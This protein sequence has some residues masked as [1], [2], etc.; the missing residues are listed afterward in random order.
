MSSV[1]C[2]RCSAAV[3]S[4]PDVGTGV[5]RCGGCGCW[6]CTGEARARLTG[7]L[8][9]DARVWEELLRQGARGPA[10][11]LCGKMFRTVSLKGVVV[12]GCDSCGALLLDPGELSRL[13][14]LEEAPPPATPNL[15]DDPPLH[16]D[17]AKL[18]KIYGDP[19]GL[20]ANF[21]GEVRWLE[22][23]QERQYGEQMLSLEFG[24]R[25]TVRAPSGSGHIFAEG[26]TAAA[27]A[28]MLL[29]GLLRSRYTMCDSRETPFLTLRRSFDRL[30]LSRMDVA[31]SSGTDDG[32]LLGSV[33]RNLRLLTSSY[34]L[35][36]ARGRRFARLERPVLSLWQF[37][38]LDERDRPVGAIAKQWSGFATEVFTD[39]D[40]FGIDFGN[41]TWSPEQRAVVLG[42]ALA[43]DLDHFERKG[44]LSSV[45]SLFD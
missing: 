21:L 23:V 8:S 17:G 3:A 15:V 33:E 13:T 40:D 38:L 34:D 42:A 35:V 14:G 25:Y 39:A 22:L 20:L 44:G 5:G 19:S 26:G 32:R 41:V 2:P 6:L 29:G 7:W 4:A 11:T 1:G 36:D 18:G 43:I 16:A 45:A 12:D 28:R 30:V 37:R 27:L 31:L 10:C 9:V 24:N